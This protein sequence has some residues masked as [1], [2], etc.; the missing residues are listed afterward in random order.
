MRAQLRLSLLIPLWGIIFSFSACLEEKSTPD[1]LI[2]LSLFT[3]VPGVARLGDS[4]KQTSDNADFAFTESSVEP[5][6]DLGKL[7][8]TSLFHFKDI[9][10]RVYFRRDGVALITAQEPFKGVIKGKKV[11]LF[12][13]SVPVISDWDALLV[14]ELGPPDTRSSGG[15]FGSEALYYSWGDISFNRM[16]PNE[17]AL[18]RTPEIG[19]YRLKNFGRELQLFPSK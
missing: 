14:R 7:G 9:G 11:R 1:K 10:T 8:F 12:S 18:Y 13:F 16:G 15:R 17:I 2:E 6:S 19:K 5:D 3:G 4:V